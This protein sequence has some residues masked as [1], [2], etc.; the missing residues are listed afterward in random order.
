MPPLDSELFPTGLLERFAGDAAEQLMRLL[1]FLS[2]LTVTTV[3]L[4]EG[5]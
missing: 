5:R 3:T 2:P 4:P 1:V